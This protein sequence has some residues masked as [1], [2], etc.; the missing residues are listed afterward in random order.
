MKHH[1]LAHR[2]RRSLAASALALS[3]L[4]GVAF[5]TI[6]ATSAPAGAAPALPTTLS[7]T[8]LSTGGTTRAVT[9]APVRQKGATTQTITNL[10][11]PAK[12]SFAG[13]TAVPEN[14]S[15][16]Y[17]CD[18]G[19]TW[20]ATSS[21]ACV[22][23]VRS[24]GDLTSLGLE[25][26]S[27]VWQG[28]Q[29]SGADTQATIKL[30]G[31]GDGW[32][33]SVN[34]D[35]TRVYNVYH[36][37][38]PSAID[39]HLT[40]DGSQCPGFRHAFT[41]IATNMA[42]LPIFGSDG[43]LYVSG[44]SG[45]SYGF[46]CVTTAGA[47]CGF[48]VVMTGQSQVR[49]QY[50]QNGLINNFVDQAIVGT[51]IYAVSQ[52]NSRLG[53]WDLNT[54]A[55]CADQPA[56]GFDVGLPTGNVSAF[57]WSHHLLAIG[58]KLFL[59]SDV[60]SGWKVGCF[61]TV[62]AQPCGGAWPLP[63]ADSTLVPTPSPMTP[64]L[65]SLGAIVLCY[66][67]DGTV[68]PTP[69]SLATLSSADPLSARTQLGNA[70]VSGTRIYW[71]AGTW[72][73][74]V[75]TT[76]DIM[77][78]D[79]ATNASCP[80]FPVLASTV[81]AAAP[82]SNGT[83]YAVLAD[84]TRTS[85]VWSNDN[86][87]NI[88]SWDTATGTAGCP[89]PGQDFVATYQASE[90][91][92][93]LSCGG[94]AVSSWGS[95][96]VTNISG[97]YTQALLTVK[98]AAGATVS[99]WDAKPIPLV[100]G[101][102]TISLASLDPTASGPQPQ[103]Q[104]TLVGLDSA[105]DS[106]TLTVSKTGS[107]PQLC[108]TLRAKAFC[109]SIAA[110]TAGAAPKAFTATLDSYLDVTTTSGRAPTISSSAGAQVSAPSLASCQI[111]P[112]PPAAT[113]GTFG[114]LGALKL[115]LT[116]PGNTGGALPRALI[117]HYRLNGGPWQTATPD[118]NGKVVI[119]GLSGNTSYCVDVAS[120]NAWGWSN[121]ASVGCATTHGTWSCDATQG[122]MINDGRL[123]T[124][125]AWDSMS[126]V[127]GLNGAVNALAYN[128]FDQLLYAVMNGPNQHLVQI[129]S[130][131]AQI[132]LGPI[133]GLPVVTGKGYVAGDLDPSTGI[134]YVSS[135]E[136]VLYAIDITSRTATRVTVPLNVQVAGGLG[137]DFAI[138][139]GFIWSVTKSN[140]VGFEPGASSGLVT[141]LPENMR[142]AVPG[143]VWSVNSLGGIAWQ[144]PRPHSESVWS[145]SVN[146]SGFVSNFQRQGSSVLTSGAVYDGASC[147]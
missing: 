65:C 88:I 75:G 109:P 93:Q 101:V 128:P 32:A 76:H 83:L 8:S 123:F 55:I 124:G 72:D 96:K 16:E 3:S 43:N 131:G 48:D 7:S 47:Y 144:A 82:S 127:G 44:N 31:V 110:M 10:F 147:R 30:T 111:K 141:P 2:A 140:I 27:Q 34:P 15:E 21:D 129:A 134:Y 130:D 42:P 116:P 135:A 77:C 87:G 29:T 69:S 91:M 39:C 25:A 92:P 49:D 78:F 86:Y 54:G 117:Y 67:A 33:A 139:D 52:S 113:L 66:E 107:A 17:T 19:Q 59:S 137:A 11:N 46:E 97:S 104:V 37:N 51:K 20:T 40:S 81:S 4:A 138:R 115:G 71:S 23:G 118:A 13:N 18:H 73:R 145:V 84:P 94:D 28:S 80:N 136:N 6:V 1:P 112:D 62:T 133:S 126:P 64:G 132:D 70:T 35:G 68:I 120:Q 63:G 99:G 60:A 121:T 119:D 53:C 50:S 100:K 36:H 9:T 125:T 38:S 90:V 114:E 122:F 85:C 5:G 146:G 12:F 14:W 24:T 61:D 143:A 56:N 106:A 41:N 26:G 108:F 74:S 22:D 79:A 57:S 102:P 105:A 142:G 89:A 103:F 58:T 45:S 95:L 98:T